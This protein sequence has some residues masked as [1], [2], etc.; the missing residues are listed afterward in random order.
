MRDNNDQ[1]DRRSVL[2]ALGTTAMVGAGLGAASGSGAARSRDDTLARAYADETRLG[3]AFAQHGEGLRQTLVDEGFV[4]E[5]FDFRSLRFDLDE[6]V[7]GLEP[8]AENGLAGVAAIV[9]EGTPTAFG[10]ASTSSDTHEIALFVQPE[11][12]EAYAF[13]EPKDGGDRVVVTENQVSPRGCTGTTCTDSCCGDGIAYEE[14]YECNSDCSD[15][16]VTDRSCGCDNCECIQ[17]GH[18]C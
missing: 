6:R 5:D 10:M 13:V 2:K 16:W 18:T 8:T 7:T 11:R 15:C 9:E 12:D 17:H 1:L 4:A 14:T 3:F